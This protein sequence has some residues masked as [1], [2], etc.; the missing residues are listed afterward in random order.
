MTTAAAAAT[1]LV[2]SALVAQGFAW[3][4]LF[5][6]FS[7][8][9]LSNLGYGGRAG[10]YRAQPFLQSPVEV[11]EELQEN[12]VEPCYGRKCTSNENC[13]PGSVCVDVD[14]IVGSCLFAYGLKQGELC[15]R[16]ND[17]ET[18]LLCSDSGGEPRTC[19]PPNRTNKQYNE[20][21]TMSGECDVTRGLCCQLQRRHRQ[22]PRKVC[23]YF[24]DPLT[25]IG[26]V[27]ADQVKVAVE[28]TAGEKRITSKVGAFNHLR[29]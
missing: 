23:S 17:C 5:N 3:G 25:C 9:M 15:R 14:G 20:D 29:K 2:L 22:A 8:E 7:P 27:A 16:D 18:G 1:L 12:D 6:R 26:T 19:Q 21:C 13:C 10:P 24:K 11:L 4:G 28:H